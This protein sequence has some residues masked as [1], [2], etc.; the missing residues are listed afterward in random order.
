VLDFFGFFCS[1]CDPNIF[2]MFPIAPHFVPYALPNIVLLELIV[3][4]ILI[5]MF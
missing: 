5:N 1:Q 4:P 3:G 2:S